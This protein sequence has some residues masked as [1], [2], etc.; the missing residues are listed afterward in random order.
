MNSEIISRWNERVRPRDTVYFLGDFCHGK[1][2]GK[3]LKR[4]HGKIVFIIGNHDFKNVE[5]IGALGIPCHS[6]LLIK[7]NKTFLWLSHYPH[8][9]WPHRAKD[10]VHFHGHSHGSLPPYKNSLDVGVDCWDFYPI[11]IDRAVKMARSAGC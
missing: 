7:H 3:Y 2:P 4:L 1:D 11:N 5:T 6:T 10:S 9:S 8:R